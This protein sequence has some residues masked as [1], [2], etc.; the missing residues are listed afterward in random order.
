MPKGFTGVIL[1]V[2]L[3][4]GKFEKI[5]MPENFY[6]LYMGGTAFGAFRNLPVF[7]GTIGRRRIDGVRE[8]MEDADPADLEPIRSSRSDFEIVGYRSSP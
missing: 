5:N 2:N 1:R 3:T 4:E 7:K 8:K 6:R